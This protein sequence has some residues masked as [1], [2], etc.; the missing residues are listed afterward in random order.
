MPIN[1]YPDVNFHHRSQTYTGFNS[2]TG[3]VKSR[4]GYE[5]RV[6]SPRQHLNEVQFA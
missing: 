3:D 1:W 5:G 2:S 4:H 6:P